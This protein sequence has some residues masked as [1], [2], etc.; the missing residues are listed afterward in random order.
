[1]LIFLFTTFRMLKMK[2]DI[3]PVKKDEMVF[4]VAQF[5]GVLCGLLG[6]LWIFFNMIF[7][8]G[9]IIH[10]KVYGMITCILLLIPYALIVSYWVFIKLRGKV[11]DW[12]DE[13]QWKDV[14]RAG[15]ATLLISIP[16][17]LT[18]FIVTFKSLPGGVFGILWFPFYLFTVLLIFSASTL[19][20]YNRT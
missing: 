6:L 20:F 12:Y 5:V 3:K 19:Y 14:A 2:K 18:F 4:T 13:K 10:I 15:F 17:M 7:N 8:A 16:V 1:M 9:N 11:E